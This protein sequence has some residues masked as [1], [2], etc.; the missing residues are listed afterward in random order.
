MTSESPC[1]TNGSTGGGGVPG[2]KAR[3][4]QRLQQLGWQDIMQVGAADNNLQH[5]ALHLHVSLYSSRLYCSSGCTTLHCGNSVHHTQHTPALI[6][7]CAW[8]QY[9][10]HCLAGS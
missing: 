8:Q 10:M 2:S 6:G 4:M 3:V 7:C 1:F 5:N 9:F